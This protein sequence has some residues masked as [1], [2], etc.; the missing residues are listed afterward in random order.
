MT[1]LLSPRSVLSG[2]FLV[3]LLAQPAAA[4]PGAPQVTVLPDNSVLLSYAAPVTPPAET[5]LVATHNG[6]PIGPFQIGMATTVSSGGPLPPGAY[7]VQVVWGGGIA[8]PVTTFVIGATAPTSP[9]GPA[10]ILPPQVSGTTV[11]LRWL[12]IPGATAYDVQVTLQASGQSIVLRFAGTEVSV[13]QVPQGG[14]S[15][16]VRGVNQHGAGSYSAPVTVT[17]PGS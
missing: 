16:R 1:R 13:P 2:T 3:W 9:P 12:A 5:V 15:V 6:V 7:S 4:N 11:T 8:S 14:Y 10:Q 17:V